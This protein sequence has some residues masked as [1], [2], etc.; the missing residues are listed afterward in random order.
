VNVVLS[1]VTAVVIMSAEKGRYT[2]IFAEELH[3]LVTGEKKREK[4]HPH[5]HIT[6]QHTHI[7]RYTRV[8]AEE[9]HV[10]AEEVQY[11]CGCIGW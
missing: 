9:V 8:F 7:G 4:T 2:S 6:N 11:L 3:H 10:F 1:F 5:P